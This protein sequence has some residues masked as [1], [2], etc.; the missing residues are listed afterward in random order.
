MAGTRVTPTLGWGAQPGIKP[1]LVLSQGTAVVQSQGATE[2]G[3]PGMRGQL[4]F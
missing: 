3:S 2:E 1:V 4:V